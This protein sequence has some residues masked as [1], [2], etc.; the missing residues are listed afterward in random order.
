MNL[1]SNNGHKKSEMLNRVPS[2]SSIGKTQLPALNSHILIITSNSSK[3]LVHNN[4]SINFSCLCY[5]VWWISFTLLFNI[6]WKWK[7]DL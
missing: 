4:W 1:H 7:R 3:G 5:W 6:N 2:R